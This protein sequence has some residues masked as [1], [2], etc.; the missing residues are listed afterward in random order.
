M[1]RGMVG[2]GRAYSSSECVASRVGVEITPVYCQG[3]FIDA[4]PSCGMPRP[5]PRCR[6]LEQSYTVIVSCVDSAAYETPIT[7]TR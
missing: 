1:D 3:L 7:D 2:C 6:N 5:L 4:G